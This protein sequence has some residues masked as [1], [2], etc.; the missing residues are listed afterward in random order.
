MI[1]PEQ[2]QEAGHVFA[3]QLRTLSTNLNDEKPDTVTAIAMLSLETNSTLYEL[4]AQI[5]MRQDQ[6]VDLLQTVSAQLVTLANAGR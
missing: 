5:I 2:F 6:V 4:G 3:K 1:N